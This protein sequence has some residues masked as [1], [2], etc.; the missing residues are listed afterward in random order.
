MTTQLELPMTVRK[1]A[2]EKSAEDAGELIRLLKDRPNLQRSPASDLCAALDWTD[3]RLRAAAQSA[4]GLIL[5]APGCTGYRLAATTSVA[6]Y[7]AVERPRYL[8]QIH[9]M[10]TRLAAM[11]RAVHAAMA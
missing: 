7:Y 2:E 1:S 10:Q 5:S 3:R 11:D 4:K 9:D 6:S 8:S